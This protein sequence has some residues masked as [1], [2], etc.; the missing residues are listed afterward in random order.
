M[1]SNKRMD[2]E[3]TAVEFMMNSSTEDVSAP[4]MRMAFAVYYALRWARGRNELWPTK[5]LEKEWGS[6][7]NAVSSE[8]SVS[9]CSECLRAIE[10]SGICTNGCKYD[11]DLCR[12][13]GA[14]IIR[15][16]L[17]TDVLL[18]EIVK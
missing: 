9:F 11:R 12:P 14:T 10:N 5:Y 4:R 6:S 18:S 2:E 1:K 15:K 8:V 3:I 17:R 13:K 16:F 7:R